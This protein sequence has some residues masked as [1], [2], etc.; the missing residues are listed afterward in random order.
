MRVTSTL[1]YKLNPLA[2]LQLDLDFRLLFKATSRTLQD[3][4]HNSRWFSGELGVTMAL[5]TWRQKPRQHI[6]AH[7]I[8]TDGGLCQ[9]KTLDQHNPERLPVPD[10]SPLQDLSWNE[11]HRL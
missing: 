5:Y 9:D 7:C 11:N 4:G 1:P 8:V 2:H 6:H 10:K 3:F